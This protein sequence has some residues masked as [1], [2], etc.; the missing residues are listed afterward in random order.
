MKS[1]QQ[2]RTRERHDM[3]NIQPVI[4]VTRAGT[5]AQTLATV[6]TK[7]H[8]LITGHGGESSRIAIVDLEAGLPAPTRKTGRVTVFDAA[9][10]NQVIKDNSDAGNIAIYFDR[11]PN[12]PSVVA[13][14]NGNGTEG[15]GWGDFRANIEFRPTPQ[16]VKWKANDGKLL[17][18]VDFAEFVEENL[19]DIADPAG[20]TMLEIA[21]QL[22]LVR[23]VNFRSKVTL[24]SGAFAF[25]HDQDDKASVGA[26]TI[27][28]PQT[29]TLGIPPIF[30]LAAY[31]VPARFRYRIAEG[32]LMLGYKLQRVET[33]M[34]QIVEDV[35]AKIERGANVS[36]MDG[37]PPG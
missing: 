34:E 24:Q 23:S 18:Q 37:L 11:N 10:F 31:R 9:S 21:S 27:D 20:A 12:K 1:G 6:G 3:D 29:F 16:W 7:Q 32:K 8:V 25:T 4:D 26:G 14:L 5:P 30:G 22:Q 2:W 33:M 36:V 17:S 35:I 28:V 15:P 13:V 19:E